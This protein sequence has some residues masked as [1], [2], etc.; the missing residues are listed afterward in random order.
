MIRLISRSFLSLFTSS[1]ATRPAFVLTRIFQMSQRD[2]GTKTYE[3]AVYQLNGLQSNAETLANFYSRRQLTE[4]N[5]EETSNLLKHLNISLESI[6][7]LNCIHI[8]GTKGKGSTAAFVESILR[9]LGYK[10][11]F[12]SSPH[13]VHVRE[14]IRIDGKPISETTFA[15]NFFDVL[16]KLKEHRTTENLPGYFKFLTLLA[17]KVF[18]VELVDVAIIEVGIGGEH[19]CTNVLKNPIVCGITSLDLDHTRLLGN[20]IA[21]IAWQKAGI[22]KKDSLLVSVRQPSEALQVIQQRSQEKEC[23]YLIAPELKDYI[24]PRTVSFG[25][26]GRHQVTNVSLALQL[27]RFWL[28]RTKK[29]ENCS[30]LLNS[31]TDFSYTPDEEKIPLGYT[32]PGIFCDGLENC[33]WPGRSQV[34]KKKSSENSSEIIYF[35]DSAHTPQSIKYCAEWFK[36]TSTNENEPLRVLVFHCTGDRSSSTLL[37]ALQEC[38]FDSA[39]FCPVRLKPVVDKHNDNTNINQSDEAEFKK[40]S[41]D[42]DTWNQLIGKDCS[43]AFGCIQ[44]TLEYVEKLAENNSGLHVL[45]TGSLHLVG[46]VLYFQ[47][48][49]IAD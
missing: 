5:V 2:L 32:I 27:A 42:A 38:N 25:I 26:P 10:T 19:D 49:D 16:D 8:T 48:P 29:Y 33:R 44:E 7:S 45:V 14:R 18:L 1:L 17:F 15:K 12:Y 37:P 9:N 34:L 13:L 40:S 35:L 23:P 41:V 39:L 31:T 20:T 46:G 4:M 11:G 43:I 28:L 21:E 47:N 36:E 22:M 6:D 30:N 24:W 3:E